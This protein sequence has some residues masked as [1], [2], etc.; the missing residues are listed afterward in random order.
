MQYMLQ[1]NIK[2]FERSKTKNLFSILEKTKNDGKLMSDF[3]N[4]IYE[5][6]IRKQKN[7]YNIIKYW[8]ENENIETSNLLI[9]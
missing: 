1:Y 5:V 8:R 7:Y 3:K 2:P 4:V 9:S 6:I